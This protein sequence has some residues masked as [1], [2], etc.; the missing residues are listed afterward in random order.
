VVGETCNPS[1]RGESEK[2]GSPLFFDFRLDVSGN[3]N[4]YGKAKYHGKGGFGWISVKRKYG[5]PYS[6]SALPSDRLS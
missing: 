5:R 4:L 3:G 2:S 1:L 6:G